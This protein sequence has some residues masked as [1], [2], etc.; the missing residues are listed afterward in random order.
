MHDEGYKM[1]DAGYRSS[2]IEL[3]RASHLPTFTICLIASTLFI[4]NAILRRE[5]TL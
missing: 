5:N 4:M 3:S 1:Q 2:I